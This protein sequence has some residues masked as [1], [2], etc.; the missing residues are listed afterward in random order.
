[1]GRISM[2]LITLDASEVPSGLLH[3]GAEVELM[4]P[5]ISPDDLARTGATIGY[6]VLTRLGSRLRRHYVG[7]GSAVGSAD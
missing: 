3:P 1:V 5:N 2:D 4:G 6:E 7:G